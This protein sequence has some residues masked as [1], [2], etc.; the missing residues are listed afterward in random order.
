MLKRH[1]ALRPNLIQ[2]LLSITCFVLTLTENH[3]TDPVTVPLRI[4]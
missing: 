4:W 3:E 2:A 1:F